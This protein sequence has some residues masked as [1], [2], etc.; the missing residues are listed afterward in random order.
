MTVVYMALTVFYVVMTVLYVVLT[1]LYVV[2]TVL[3]VV[4]TVLCVASSPGGEGRHRLR[5]AGVA[6]GRRR[7]PGPHQGGCLWSGAVQRKLSF[8]V[9]GGC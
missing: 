3:C 9:Q 1:V 7:W 6:P 5:T 4:M 2:I 8:R